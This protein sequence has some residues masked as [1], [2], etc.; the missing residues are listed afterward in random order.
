MSHSYTSKELFHFVGSNHPKNDEANFTTLL[1]ILKSKCISYGPDFPADIRFRYS[2]NWDEMHV[3]EGGLIVPQVTCYCDI[4]LKDLDLHMRKYGK[5]GLSFARSFLISYGARPVIYVPI[6]PSD[7]RSGWGSIVGEMMVCNWMK[8][9]QGYEEHAVAPIR[10]PIHKSTLNTKPGTREDAVLAV[11]SILTA[12]FFAFI[13]VF[14]SD[15]ED[16]DK[17]NFYMEREWRMINPLKFMLDDIESVFIQKV[18]AERLSIEF[19]TLASKVVR[20]D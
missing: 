3:L 20:I 11:N 13:K 4:P 1:K 5:F 19:P 16:D 15:L 6:Q 17:D 18:Y 14:N 9:W 7:Y 10:P 8:V 2:F 12:E